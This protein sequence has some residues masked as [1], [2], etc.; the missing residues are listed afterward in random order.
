MVDLVKQL[1][2]PVSEESAQVMVRWAADEIEQRK[3]QLWKYGK[4]LASCALWKSAS[5]A[6]DCGWVEVR[7]TLAQAKQ[8]DA[9]AFNASIAPHHSQSD[10]E[11][12]HSS[13]ANDGKAKQ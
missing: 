2:E 10:A 7:S 12:K 8:S 4:H 6:C 13:S 1:R 3:A 9:D 11:A 5:H